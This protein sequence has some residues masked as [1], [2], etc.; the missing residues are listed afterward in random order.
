M[1]YKELSIVRLDFLDRENER[2][3]LAR[4]F[5]GS[6]GSFTCLFGR[7]RCGKSRLIQEVLPPRRSV[8]YVA[9]ER[10]SGLQIASLATTIADLMPGFDQVTYP[11]WTSLLERWW[12]EAPDGAVL[13]QGVDHLGDG[14]F[15]P[16]VRD[17]PAAEY[18]HRQQHDDG[19][20]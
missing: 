14:P 10:E 13:A 8:Y 3:R 20:D 7:R 19:V 15:D 6:E 5:T 16:V 18:Q 1:F 9:D 2:S 17:H 4:A 11:D 12:R